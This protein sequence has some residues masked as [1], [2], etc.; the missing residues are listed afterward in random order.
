MRPTDTGE[1]EERFVAVVAAQ[2]GKPLGLGAVPPAQHPNHGGFEVVVTDPGRNRT[3][4]GERRYVSFQERFLGL[5]A[6]RDVESLTG[7]GKSHH[8]QPQCGQYPGDSGAEL[9]EIDLGLRAGRVG[10]RH[11]H[12]D[13]VQTQLDP[14]GGDVTRHG[15]F[16]QHRVVLGDQSLPDSP[17]G[18]SLFAW[19][20]PV[21]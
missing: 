19:H 8:E 4:I 15:H 6:E 18:V 17:R 7:V 1:A 5:G 11:R 13:P 9:A 3:E 16:R 12:L 10:L 21:G 14:T 2:R 20:V